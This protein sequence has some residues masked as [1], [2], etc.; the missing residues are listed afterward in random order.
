[1]FRAWKHAGHM[2]V[3]TVTRLPKYLNVSTELR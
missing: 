3:N 1:M 2:L